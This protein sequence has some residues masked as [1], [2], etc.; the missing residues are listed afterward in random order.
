VPRDK[1]RAAEVARILATLGESA[2]Q[3]A[4]VLRVSGCR[5]FRR[6]NFPSPVVRYVYRWFDDGQLVLVHSPPEAHDLL[7]R[8]DRFYLYLLD[9]KREEVAVPAA[10]AEFLV[11]F[12]AGAF[13]DLELH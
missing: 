2:D 1:D 7:P 3:V 11:R 9:G 4:D 6:G 13:A 5:G 8:P 10:V 12:D